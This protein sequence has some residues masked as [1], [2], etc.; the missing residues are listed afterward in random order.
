MTKPRRWGGPTQPSS[1]FETALALESEY[2]STII[3][4]AQRLGYL[5]CHFRPAR[6]ARGWRTSLEGTPGFPD[7]VVVGYGRIWFI[8]LKRQ[9]NKPSGEQLLWLERLAEAGMN[10]FVAYVPEHLQSI[11][12]DLT[13]WRDQAL[14]PRKD[15]PL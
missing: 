14:N 7:L 11:I 6:T 5:A 4:A 8:E 15:T 10:A 9:P 13:Q 1:L 3:E 12:D 2:T